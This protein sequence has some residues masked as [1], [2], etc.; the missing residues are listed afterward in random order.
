VSDLRGIHDI[1]VGRMEMNR[2]KASWFLI[3][4]VVVGVLTIVEGVSDG[5]TSLNWVVIGV[6]PVFVVLSIRTLAGK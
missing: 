1:R 4:F 2:S 6:S 5:F 3:A